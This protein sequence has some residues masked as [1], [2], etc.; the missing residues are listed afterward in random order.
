MDALRRSP[1]PM[2]VLVP[3]M[4]P[5]ND[6]S[7]PIQSH[8][9]TDDLQMVIAKWD[10]ASHAFEP[11]AKGEE[12]QG[13]TTWT[14]L[15]APGG[16]NFR[17]CLPPAESPVGVC[18]GTG[19]PAEARD[20][21]LTWPGRGESGEAPTEARG[22]FHTA[23]AAPQEACGRGAQGGARGRGGRGTMQRRPIGDHLR[24]LQNTDPRKVIV[25]RKISDL[26]F[27]SAAI[28]RGHYAK[29]GPVQQ[30]RVVHSNVKSTT[31]PG[32]MRPASMGFVVMVKAGDA[33]AIL[34]DGED[35]QV[36][37]CCI[38]VHPFENRSF[39]TGQGPPAPAAR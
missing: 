7:K 2:K 38:T 24:D 18:S 33:E 12:N 28:V 3:D 5:L 21:A 35:Q 6:M 26:G 36:A 13:A 22:R 10:A 4:A 11:L 29:Y 39:D 31:T 17:D 1:S 14:G 37:G 15:G 16:L 32:R 30:V 20:R 9:S 19:R 8:R 25:V 23:P 34:R 27:N